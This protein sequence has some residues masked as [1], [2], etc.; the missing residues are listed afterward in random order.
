MAKEAAKK[1]DDEE[2]AKGAEDKKEDKKEEKKDEKDAKKGDAKEGEGEG[3]AK[4]GEAAEGEGAPKKS[5]KKLIIIGA[6]ALVVLI[7]GAA[8]AYFAF[9]SK[10]EETAEEGKA[11]DKAAAKAVYYSLPEF[12]VNLNSGGKQ[13]SFLKMT[14]IL[15]LESQLDVLPLEGDLPKLMDSFNTYLRELRSSDL[16]GSAGIQRLREELLLRANNAVAPIKVRD[17]LFK[18]II[19]Q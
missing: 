13:T 6:I 12:L 5:K 2:E 16:S 8:G 9:F 7:A 14:V 11:G 17:V 18:E 1:K 4:E 19:V 3:E 10:H 15:E